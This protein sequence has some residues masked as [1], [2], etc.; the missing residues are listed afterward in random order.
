MREP[1]SLDFSAILASSIHDMKNSLGMVLS[2]LDEI[3]DQRREECQCTAEQVA[4]LQYEAKRV[5]DNLVQLLTLY[6]IQE[7]RYRPHIDEYLVA[8]FLEEVYLLNLPLLQHRHVA[9]EI[10]C[11]PGLTWY[12]DRELIIGVINNVTHN[13]LRYTHDRLRM[14]ARE[15]GAYLHLYIEDNGGGFPAAMTQETHSELDFQ[16]GRTGLGLYF[17][18]LVASMHENG[19]REGRIELDNGSSLGGARFSLWLP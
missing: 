10:D 17:C 4:Q 5:N 19:E 14:V 9:M 16:S 18:S 6:R 3:V 2:S 12:F 13:A 8:E 11:D 15:E 7:R 1:R